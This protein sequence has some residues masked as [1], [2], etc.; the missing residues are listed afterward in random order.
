MSTAKPK[1]PYLRTQVMTAGPGELRLMLLDGAIRFA[2]QAKHA[3]AAKDFEAAY[4]GFVRA[5]DIIMEL[6]GALSPEQDPELYKRLSGLYTYIY[7]R[8]VSAS[9]ER[10]PSLVDEA[11]QLLQYERETWSLVLSKLASE[12]KRA[13]ALEAVPEEAPATAVPDERASRLVGGRVSVS[14]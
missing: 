7:Q 6:L 10:E 14:G 12:N 5:Q 1:N 9:S 8:L 13:G 2:E 3:V 11:I 4:N